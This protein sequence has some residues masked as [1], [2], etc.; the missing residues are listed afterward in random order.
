MA[1]NF[2]EGKKK[3]IFCVSLILLMFLQYEF[4]IP[5]AEGRKE[6][7]PGYSHHDFV[8]PNETVS[9][10]FNPSNVN[11]EISSNTL[12][13]LN[14]EYGPT[15]SDRQIMF[16]VKNSD[17]MTLNISSTTDINSYGLP[18]VPQEPSRGNYRYQYQYN[19]IYKIRSN[20][21][22]ENLTIQYKKILSMV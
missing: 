7:I 19:C 3:L 1:L 15:I 12:I 14:I 8:N 5:D 9:Y 17:S 16:I 2:I 11:F 21:T 18:G 13:E 20:Q 10:N 6:T 22:I 4:I